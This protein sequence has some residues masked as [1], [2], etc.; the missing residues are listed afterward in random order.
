[1]NVCDLN[2]NEHEKKKKVVMNL[3]SSEFE[4]NNSTVRSSN[5]GRDEL[6]SS[7]SWATGSTTDLYRLF[8]ENKLLKLYKSS[9]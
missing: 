6:E 8:F 9:E 7:S 1:M 4:G 3:H 5:T 2:I